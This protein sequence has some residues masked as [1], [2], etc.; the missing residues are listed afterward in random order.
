MVSG[1]GLVAR[2]VSVTVLGLVTGVLASLATVVFLQAIELM[3]NWFL[4]SAESRAMAAGTDWLLVATIAVPALGGLAVGLVSLKIPGKRAGGPQDVIEA[5]H[6][7]DS[8]MA[9]RSGFLS[10][11]ASLLSLGSG[12]SVGHYGPLVHLGATLGSLVG[13]TGRMNTWTIRVGVGCGVAAAIAAAFNAPIAG[14]IFA[15]EVILRHYS[16]R[17]F[18]P[19]TVA[20]TASHVM[21]TVVFAHPPLFEVAPVSI[22][23]V[24]E[25]PGFIVIGILSA[26]VAV[27]YMRAILFSQT[28]GERLP[29]PSCLKPMAA[30]VA[31][32]IAALWLPGIL[33]TGTDTMR[34]AIVDGAF[35]PSGLAILLVAKIVATALCLGCGFA[36]GV[37]TPALFVGIFFGAL[38]GD[39]AYLVFGDLRS[40]LSVYAICGMMAVASAVIG[41]PLAT[42]LI[43][44]ELTRNYDL[45][46]ATMVS[47]VFSNVVCYRMFGRSIFD[48]QLRQRGFDLS[49][50][51]DRVMAGNMLIDSHVSR[52]FTALEP[53]MTPDEAMARLVKNHHHEAYVLDGHGVIIGRVR[54]DDLVDNPREAAT[55]SALVLPTGPVLTAG[56]SIRDAM[57]RIRRTGHA[58]IPVVDVGE[59]AAM[60]GVVTEADLARVFLDMASGIRREEHA[61]RDDSVR[62][63]NDVACHILRQRTAGT[64]RRP[65]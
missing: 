64:R 60:L 63:G 32:G 44:F 27:A 8:R 51:R 16:L 20:A 53:D 15:H 13:F 4:I 46:T 57:E 36:G 56:M 38:A 65:I 47:V 22:G 59:P 24:G 18:A 10:A 30:G 48:V 40:D 34:L 6:V 54:F 12:A 39:A 45:T 61:S 25:Y 26:L 14:I 50:G 43:V 5:V 29:I 19:V 9:P 37:F 41:A 1:T 3:N 11:V 2:I 58:S 28:L 55:I 42:I 31:L 35:E 21:V 33:G 17:A 52:D 7:A 49:L 23:H 62:A